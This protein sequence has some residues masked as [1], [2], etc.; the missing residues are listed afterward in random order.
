MTVRIGHGVPA[1]GGKVTAC[2]PMAT[3][4]PLGGLGLREPQHSGVRECGG[5]FNNSKCKGTLWVT[6]SQCLPPPIYSPV[7][8][9]VTE[10]L[11]VAPQNI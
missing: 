7:S 4:H 3:L 8:R 2:I 1:G 10:W 11:F 5:G 6:S 9:G